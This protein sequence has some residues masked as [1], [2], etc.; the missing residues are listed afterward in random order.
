MWCSFVTFEV[1]LREFKHYL[2]NVPLSYLDVV[3]LLWYLWNGL[4]LF[5]FILTDEVALYWLVYEVNI[6]S[7]LITFQYSTEQVKT[8]PTS[9]QGENVSFECRRSKEL[10]SLNWINAPLVR[11]THIYIVLSRYEKDLFLWFLW[12]VEFSSVVYP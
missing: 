7:L 3:S 1:E 9:C 8:I 10:F 5:N 6:S 4:I 12:R 11:S 2:K